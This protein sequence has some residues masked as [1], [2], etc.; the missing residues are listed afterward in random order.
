MYKSFHNE[1]NV[2][3]D[4]LPL[5]TVSG[6]NTFKNVKDSAAV[7]W[8]SAAVCLLLFK[9]IVRIVA[10][11]DTW[12]FCRLQLI[13]TVVVT[14]SKRVGCLLVSSTGWND[15]LY[16]FPDISIKKWKYIV[17]FC[18]LRVAKGP[19]KKNWRWLK[20]LHRLWRHTIE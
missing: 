16:R 20:T 6:F 4:I 19:Y 1:T 15:A 11:I 7:N 2:R 10:H 5:T 9:N 14:C 17:Q 13:E 12:F 18:W 8:I 3:G